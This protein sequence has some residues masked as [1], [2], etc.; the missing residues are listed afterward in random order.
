MSRGMQRDTERSAK[1]RR[2]QFRAFLIFQ[3]VFW[4]ANFTIRTL[5][6]IAHRP[7]YVLTFMPDRALVTA[8][9]FAATTAIHLVLMRFDHWRQTHRL[10]LGLGLCVALLAPMNALERQLAENVGAN[11]DQVTFADYVLQFGWAYLM[12]AGYYFAQDLLFR[13]RRHADQLARAQAQA[14]AAQLQM[15]RHQLNP[16]FLFNSLNA[17]STLVLEARNGDAERML[18][19]LSRFLRRVADPSPEPL[20]RLGEEIAVQRLYLEVEAV[21]FAEKLQIT[22][23]V[24]EPLHDCLV[25]TLLLQPIV[26]NAIKHGI[27]QLAEGGAIHIAAHGRDKRLVLSVENDGPISTGSW[28]RSDGLGLRNTT[29]RLRVLYGDDASLTLAPRPEGGARVEIVMPLQTVPSQAQFAPV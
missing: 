28:R 29:E 15:L 12:W 10:V 17:I 1:W 18:M 22:S 9:S 13:T 23:D 19:N 20:A 2:E 7:E 6:A 3:V 8:V 4:G 24:P 25:P 16:H 5:A 14:H 11:L 21:R 26:E 27:A